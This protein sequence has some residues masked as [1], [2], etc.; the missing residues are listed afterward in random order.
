MKLRRTIL[1]AAAATAVLAT[2]AAVFPGSPADRSQPLPA[3]TTTRWPPATRPT[4]G[5]WPGRPVGPPGGRHRP[6]PRA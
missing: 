3:L 2:S 6:G 5:S 1:I 4:R